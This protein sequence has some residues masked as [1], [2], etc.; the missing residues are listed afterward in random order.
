MQNRII[1]LSDDSQMVTHP[2]TMKVYELY[3]PMF[4]CTPRFLKTKD[5][6]GYTEPLFQK[7]SRNSSTLIEIWHFEYGQPVVT[8]NECKF[9]QS[10]PKM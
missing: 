9:N 2:C 8:I 6:K 5:L 1:Q 7:R 10:I 3:A 4:H